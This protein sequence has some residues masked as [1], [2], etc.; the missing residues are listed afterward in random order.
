[1][2]AEVGLATAALEGQRISGEAEIRHGREG[3]RQDAQGER[4]GQKSPLQGRAAFLK[5]WDWELIN[6]LNRGACDRGRA[7]FGRNSE[8]HDQVHEHWETTRS[9]IL[10]LGEVLDFLRRTRGFPARRSYQDPPG[11]HPRRDRARA[12]RRQ[13]RVATGPEQ[14]RIDRIARK[15][16]PGRPLTSSENKQLRQAPPH[17]WLG[18]AQD[19]FQ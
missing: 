17:R 10:S 12:F 6:S 18:R 14:G 16:D 4:S 2:V 3:D 8:A 19:V 15:C 13:D 7:K 9:Q 1:M 11:L 5:N